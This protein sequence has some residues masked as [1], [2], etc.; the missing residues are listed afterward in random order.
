MRF[1]V[2]SPFLVPGP[3][4]L[5]YQGA[6][7]ILICSK[8]SYLVWVT[9][10]DIAKEAVSATGKGHLSHFLHEKCRVEGDF[11]VHLWCRGR[12]CVTDHVQGNNPRKS[13]PPARQTLHILSQRSGPNQC[14]C[15]VTSIFLVS[16]VP[17]VRLAWLQVTIKMCEAPD[18]TAFQVTKS[19]L[20][21]R[22][23]LAISSWTCFSSKNRSLHRRTQIHSLSLLSL[24]I[25]PRRWFKVF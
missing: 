16:G 2:T 10:Y 4:Y 19:A 8:L 20:F 18:A 25:A 22:N 3:S 12:N 6:G 11:V 21:S 24:S 9:F 15:E 17:L 1:F 7:E 14:R 23:A 5:L 13:H